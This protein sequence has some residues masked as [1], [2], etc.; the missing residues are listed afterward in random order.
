MAIQIGRKNHVNYVVSHFTV[1]EPNKQINQSPITFP[2]NVN[3]GCNIF[4][5]IH[6][7]KIIYKIIS[8]TILLSI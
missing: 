4:Q 6:G 3:I 1:H 5:M 7:R 8:T 2:N